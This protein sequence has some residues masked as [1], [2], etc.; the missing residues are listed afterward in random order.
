MESEHAKG[1]LQ[2]NFEKSSKMA[3]TFEEKVKKKHVQIGFHTA[4]AKDSEVIKKV[5]RVCVIHLKN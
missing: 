1:M 2:W 3:K 4:N 5:R